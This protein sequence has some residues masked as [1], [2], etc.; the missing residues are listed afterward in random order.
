VSIMLVGEGADKDGI[1][2][3][4]EGYHNVLVFTSCL[5]VEAPGV[6]S[7]YFVKWD[8]ENVNVLLWVLGE[9]L[10]VVHCAGGRS[11]VL[12]WLGHMALDGCISCRAILSN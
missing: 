4:M 5:R 12:L 11:D 8:G 6:I 1:C 2:V 10:L 9:S 7:E 3:G